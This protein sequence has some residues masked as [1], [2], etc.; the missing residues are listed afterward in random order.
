MEFQTRPGQR[1]QSQ[2]HDRDPAA[3]PGG[4]R[5]LP[6]SVTLTLILSSLGLC[7]PILGCSCV[8]LYSSPYNLRPINSSTAQPH[9]KVTLE[10]KDHPRITGVRPLIVH[11]R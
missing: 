7:V 4:V 9:L 1:P 11:V 3:T 5:T 8:F 2:E 10:K 6:H